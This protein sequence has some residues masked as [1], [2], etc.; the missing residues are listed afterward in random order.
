MQVGA[1]P[2]LSNGELGVDPGP[3][4]DWFKFNYLG[5][6][7]REGEINRS[8]TTINTDLVLEQRILKDFLLKG[9]ISHDFD[10]MY[11]S[12]ITADPIVITSYSIHYTKLYEEW[13]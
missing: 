2:V 4:T 5:E 6:L 1:P 10:R 13:F 8:T 7:E 11:K 12:S 9:K 3:A